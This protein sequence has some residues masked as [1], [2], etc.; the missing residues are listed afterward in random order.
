LRPGYLTRA[1]A[2]APTPSVDAIHRLLGRHAIGRALALRVLREG[3][4]LDLEA[5]ASSQLD[6]K[7]PLR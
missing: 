5:T 6:D 3:K 1:V 4:L 2:G 7:A